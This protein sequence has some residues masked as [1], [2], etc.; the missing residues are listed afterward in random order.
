MKILLTLLLFLVSEQAFSDNFFIPKNNEII[1][2]IVRKNN[3]IGT[4]S[5][6]FNKKEINTLN[7]KINVDIK[8]KIGFL[9]IYKYKHD[10][11]EVWINNELFS[12]S[13]E[14]INNK[15]KRYFVEG[16]QND[17]KFEFIGVDGKKNWERNVIPISYW[18]KNITKRNIFLDTQKGIMREL[19]VRS[20]NNDKIKFGEKTIEAKC[21]ELTVIT[22]HKT[23]QKPFPTIYVWYTEQGELMKIK[24]DSPEDNSIIDYIRIK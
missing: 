13:T 16:K 14:S 22:S 17:N 4:H 9:T 24:F 18:N 7:V 19:K 20:L 3:V 10:N 2:D 12:I 23:D 6:I 1:F 5:I 21:Y 15:N 8:V 11:N